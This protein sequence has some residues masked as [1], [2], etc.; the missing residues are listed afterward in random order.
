MLL[1]IILGLFVFGIFL[2]VIFDKGDSGHKIAWLLLVS[3][4]PFVGIGIYLLFG[5]PHRFYWL[6]KR[7]HAASEKLFR[8]EGDEK[9]KRLLSGSRGGGPAVDGDFEPLAR[10][11]SEGVKAYALT[12]CNDFEI[13]TSGR[14]KLE[15][16]MKDISA[17]KHS[18]H[19]EYYHF[20]KDKGSTI[21]R[22]LLKRKA[23]EGVEVR[24]LNENVANLPIPAS[25]YEKMRKSGIEVEN[26]T[27]PSQ[28]LISFTTKLNYRNH[29]KIVVIDGKI[30]YTG[31]MN[32]NNHY[33]FQW[34]DTHLRIEG[35]AVASLQASFIDSWIT[36]GG[37]LKRPLPDYF[38]EFTPVPGDDAPEKNLFHGKTV[39]VI[40]DDPS[41]PWPAIQMG[42]EWMLQ[43][44]KDYIY[45]QSPYF[46]PP[47]SFL[48]AIKTA[49]LR[50]VDVR[51]MLPQDV[52]TIF[53][54]PANRSYY[55]ECLEAGVKIYERGGEFIHSKTFVCDDYLS[56]IGTA[57][58]DIRSFDINYEIN[59]YIYD[60]PTAR[61]MKEIF[62]SDMPLC[63]EIKLEEWQ[64]RKWFQ[65]LFPRI[66]QLFSGVL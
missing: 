41:S 63:R 2:I 16:L 27:N 25:Y 5:M 13:I 4:L 17:A 39:Q 33:F 54:G 64:E 29:R 61:R 62:L 6:F 36:A 20:G 15:L 31:G 18:I 60:A 59:T 37:K 7:R 52:D 58:I 49:A 12:D 65:N 66:V 50:G 53:M 32:I 8:S 26:F 47:T 38:H 30:G 21:I 43:N 10:F 51:V 34:R 22:D 1:Y 44:A 45:I 11:F 46:V 40:A 48:S 9:M 24:F 23:A 42:Y 14:R 56:Q 55:E 57:N 35:N 19:I 3:L 28:G